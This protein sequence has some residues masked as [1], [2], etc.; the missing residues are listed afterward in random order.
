MTDKDAAKDIHQAFGAV[1]NTYGRILQTQDSRASELENENAQLRAQI[2]ALH[3]ATQKLTAELQH[4]KAVR[5]SFAIVIKD[6]R[7]WLVH[8][9]HTDVARAIGK[10]APIPPPP[11]EG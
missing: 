3:G 7:D 10:D 1:V 6:H 11:F 9:G 4:A 2:A 8:N 5:E